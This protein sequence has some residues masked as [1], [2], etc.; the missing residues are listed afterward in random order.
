MSGEAA[1]TQKGYYLIKYLGN[2][3]AII[4]Y[5]IRPALDRAQLTYL[6]STYPTY[7]G[8]V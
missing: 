4:R 2:Y 6:G 8:R 7:L 3:L 5:T 1:S